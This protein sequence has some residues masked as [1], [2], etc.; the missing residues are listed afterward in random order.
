M[1]ASG[2][3]RAGFS[4]IELVI[5]I[6]VVSLSVA[7]ILAVMNVNSRHSADPLV[8]KQAVDVAESLLEEVMSQSYTICDATDPNVSTAITAADCASV[9][10]SLGPN[11][12]RSR[13]GNANPPVA[14]FD[15]V[16]DYA[17]FDMNSGITTITGMPIPM[18]AGYNAH[19]TVIDA[20]TAG[21]E[22]AA[23]PSQAAGSVL[24]I[25]VNVTGAAEATLT[26]YRF[27]YD[28]NAPP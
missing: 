27:R 28:P 11:P 18:L 19:V 23:S 5:F 6:V 10:R 20:T 14:A 24:R 7:G 15:S 9:P 22:F 13:A 3:R 1:F 2:C 16:G 17:G 12:G 4:L 25:T 26:G 8:R 21:M